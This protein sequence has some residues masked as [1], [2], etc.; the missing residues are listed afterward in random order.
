VPLTELNKLLVQARA[1]HW[2]SLALSGNKVGPN[3]ARAIAA[4]L[5][6]LTSLDLSRNN[7]RDHGAM[8]VAAFLPGLNS[9]NL[10]SNHVGDEAPGPSPPYRAA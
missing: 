5:P 7:V 3:G 8:A 9:V 6:G 10:E 1:E 2:I 4:S